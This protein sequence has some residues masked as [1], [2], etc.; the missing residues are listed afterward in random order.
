MAD[1]EAVSLTK[2]EERALARLI[3]AR[4]REVETSLCYGFDQDEHFTKSEASDFCLVHADDARG[5]FY[6]TVRSSLRDFRGIWDVPKPEVELLT[7]RPDRPETLK[8]RTGPS[9]GPLGEAPFRDE[10]IEYR[11][12]K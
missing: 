2:E 5:E 8:V 4:L 3:G 11:S 6:I 9:G 10:K 7:A 12:F 1:D